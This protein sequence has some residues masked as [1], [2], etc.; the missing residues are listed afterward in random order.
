MEPL[1]SYSKYRD[2]VDFRELSLSHSPKGKGGWEGYIEGEEE[3]EGER[4]R[5]ENEEREG[6]EE[7]GEEGESK[8]KKGE[9]ERKK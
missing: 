6:E 4:E 3:G 9:R 2:F 1:I 5:E 7:G 8:G